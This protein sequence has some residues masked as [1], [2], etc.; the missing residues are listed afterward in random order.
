MR[1]TPV[2]GIAPDRR[3]ALFERSHSPFAGSHRR[4]LLAGH[5]LPDAL[6]EHAERIG[7]FSSTSR[8]KRRTSK[9]DPSSDSAWA[10]SSN[11]FWCP[12]K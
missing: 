7:P 6:L 4:L 9:R 1:D 3:A 12:T 8:W 11:S 10:R 2:A 5:P